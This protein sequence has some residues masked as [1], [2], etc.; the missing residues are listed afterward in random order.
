MKVESK[1]C[2]VKVTID[3]CVSGV[4]ANANVRRSTSAN[5]ERKYEREESLSQDDAMC[6]GW[7][8]GANKPTVV[9]MIAERVSST[10]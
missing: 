3:E 5:T 2:E 6:F 9:E 4:N 7:A 1:I 8:K 10:A